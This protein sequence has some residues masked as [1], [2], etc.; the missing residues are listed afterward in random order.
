MGVC[1]RGHEV[2]EGFAFCAVCG[3]QLASPKERPEQPEAARP[4]KKRM[5]TRHVARAT[6][7]I[8]VVAVIVAASLVALKLS[9]EP[10]QSEVW[11]KKALVNGIT[12]PTGI[13]VSPNGRLYVSQGTVGQIT[14]LTSS[15]KVVGE[16]TSGLNDPAALSMSADGRYLYA[17]E[18]DSVTRVDTHNDVTQ[19]ASLL[20]TPDIASLAVDPA[21]EACVNSKCVR[22]QSLYISSVPDGFH[23]LGDETA[24]FPWD[25]PNALGVVAEGRY[26][27]AYSLAVTPDGRTIFA[28]DLQNDTVI[29]FSANGCCPGVTIAAGRSPFIIQSN[30]AARK[31][32]SVVGSFGHSIP[33]AIA[34]SRSGAQL[35]VYESSPS[36]QQLVE[37]SPNGTHARVIASGFPQGGPLPQ[38]SVSPDGRTVYVALPGFD[39]IYE[40]SQSGPPSGATTSTTTSVPPDPSD[41]VGFTGP[42]VVLSSTALNGISVLLPSGTFLSQLSKTLGDPQILQSTFLCQ[43]GGPSFPVK[44][45]QWGDLAVVMSAGTV[46]EIEYLPGGWSAYRFHLLTWPSALPATI[47]MSPALRT[48]TGVVVGDSRS[49]VKALDHSAFMSPKG[50]GRLIAYS[51]GINLYLTA[52]HVTQIEL[53][54]ANC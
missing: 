1:E 23:G 15:G 31:Y 41:R 40:V 51:S 34:L 13:A 18:G 21:A 33:L 44:V 52:G 17:A 9:S 49:K 22:A 20:S 25:D 19:A 7:A 11:T 16:V 10:H 28:A 35:F 26:F 5:R 8:V 14:E 37:M 27:E 53:T 45:A 54:N 38:L 46:A 12:D 36:A 32:Y 24:W 42:N 43:Q 3:V 30:P 2:G 48:S 39:E 29:A 6:L 47:Q 4:I 50:S